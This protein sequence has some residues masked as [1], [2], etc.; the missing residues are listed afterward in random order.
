MACRPELHWEDMAKARLP[1]VCGHWLKVVQVRDFWSQQR[2]SPSDSRCKGG[3]L[4]NR[5]EC[6]LKRKF[7]EVIWNTIHMMI[8]FREP[9]QPQISK[10]ECLSVQCLPFVMHL[11]TVTTNTRFKPRW[12][13]MVCCFAACT[14]CCAVG[15]GCTCQNALTPSCGH[16]TGRACWCHGHAHL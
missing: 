11:D 13:S 8:F 1:Q 7:P 6:W 2:S 15:G 9:G 16:A 14:W 10:D 3:G 4:L 12:H 5:W